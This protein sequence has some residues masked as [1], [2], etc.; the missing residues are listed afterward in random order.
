MK[1]ETYTYWKDL[2]GEIYRQRAEDGTAQ[3]W[4]SISRKWSTN[5]FWWTEFE[6]VKVMKCQKISTACAVKLGVEV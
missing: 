1:T 3:Q 2:H 5:G 6:L 4:H